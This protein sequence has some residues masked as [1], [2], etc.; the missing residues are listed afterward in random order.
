MSNLNLGPK[1]R[2]CI[3]DGAVDVSSLHYNTTVTAKAHRMLLTEKEVALYH[4]NVIMS[5]PGSR[6]P[7]S[8]TSA[9]WLWSFETRL[10][11]IHLDAD[12]LHNNDILAIVAIVHIS[13]HFCAFWIASFSFFFFF[14]FFFLDATHICTCTPTKTRN[15]IAT[16]LQKYR[17]YTHNRRGNPYDGEESI[18]PVRHQHD[19]YSTSTTPHHHPPTT[20]W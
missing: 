2:S 4:V 19:T 15:T 20:T 14:F 7:G 1:N 5:P 9:G 16:R 11:T 18:Q 13:S 3:H 10:E 17:I 12:A 6:T 8:P